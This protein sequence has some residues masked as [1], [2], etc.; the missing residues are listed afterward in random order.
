MSS[1]I[2]SI[3]LSDGSSMPLLGLGTYDSVDENELTT[4]VKAAIK[5]GYRH[6]DCGT[7]QTTQTIHT[8]SHFYFASLFLSKRAHYWQSYPRVNR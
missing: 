7:L 6:F 4:A 3:T 1:H 5:H 8:A 2:P